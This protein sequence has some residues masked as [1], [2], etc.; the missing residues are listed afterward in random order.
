MTFKQLLMTF[1]ASAVWQVPEIQLNSS[2]KANLS[3]ILFLFG[4]ITDVRKVCS[5]IS[6][7]I[8]NVNHKHCSFSRP[9]H[10]YIILPS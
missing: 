10:L 7:I 6:E 8:N 9:I 3:P 5:L 1:Y 2:I 4:K